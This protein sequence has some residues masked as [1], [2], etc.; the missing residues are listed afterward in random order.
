MSFFGGRSQAAEDIQE[1]LENTQKEITELQKGQKQQLESLEELVKIAQGIGKAVTCAE[2][3]Q[4][5]WSGDPDDV[6]RHTKQASELTPRQLQI[7]K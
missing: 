6:D 5:N 4:D 7:I 3:R 2:R 1:V